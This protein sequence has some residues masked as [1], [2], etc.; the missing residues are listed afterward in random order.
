[1]E[2][3]TNS[4][5]T[6]VVAPLGSGQF[7]IVADEAALEAFLLKLAQLDVDVPDMHYAP[8]AGIISTNR[9]GVDNLIASVSFEVIEC[10]GVAAAKIRFAALNGKAECAGRT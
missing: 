3:P 5:S 6:I 2:H 4:R 10:E 7:V 9:R 1:M 8:V